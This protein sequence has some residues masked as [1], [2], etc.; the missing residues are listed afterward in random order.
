MFH[1]ASLTPNQVHACIDDLREL[2]EN[3]RQKLYIVHTQDDV[4][5]EDASAFG[6]LTK[7]STRYIFR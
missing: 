1:D 5:D 7:Q 6:G 4:T 3:I 2:P